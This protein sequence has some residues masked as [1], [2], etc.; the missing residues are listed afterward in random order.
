MAFPSNHTEHNFKK[1][2][3]NPGVTPD[4]LFMFDSAMFQ[5]QSTNESQDPGNRPRDRHKSDCLEDRFCN[6]WC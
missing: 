5:L 6:S 1:L 3:A 2:Y 4:L